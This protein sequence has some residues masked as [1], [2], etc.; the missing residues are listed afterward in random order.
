MVKKNRGGVAH[1]P[2]GRAEKIRD[3]IF[4]WNFDEWKENQQKRDDA[5]KNYKKGEFVSQ[6][7]GFHKR[8]FKLQ[9]SRFRRKTFVFNLKLDARNFFRLLE[10]TSNRRSDQQKRQT[11]HDNRNRP[12][13]T[14]KQKTVFVIAHNL[15][16]VDE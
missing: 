10:N 1:S 12:R 3:I 7:G 15:A 5:G 2:V 4:K 13:Q 8:S 9:V 14:I 6:F 16:V 11:R